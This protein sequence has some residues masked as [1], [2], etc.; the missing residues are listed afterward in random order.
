MCAV[1]SMKTLARYNLDGLAPVF[2]DLEDARSEIAALKEDIS[3]LADEANPLSTVEIQAI[4]TKG[5]WARSPY[6]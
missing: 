6:R 4:E 5:E 2:E 3:S 1:E